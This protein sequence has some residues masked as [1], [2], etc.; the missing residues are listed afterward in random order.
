MFVVLVV[1]GVFAY[2]FR[3]Q[4]SRL[5]N[6]CFKLWTDP[7]LTS[8]F[9]Q[10]TSNMKPEMIATLRDYDPSLTNDPVTKAWDATQ[11]K[12]SKLWRIT[13]SYLNK[14]FIFNQP[15]HIYICRV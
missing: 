5:K 8:F 6:Q 7:T 2:V 11:R 15:F 10:I 12:V 9:L 14:R 3:S 13:S 4:V 1:G